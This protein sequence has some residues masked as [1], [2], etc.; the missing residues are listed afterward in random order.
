MADEDDDGGLGDLLKRLKNGQ[1]EYPPDL[2]DGTRM[3]Y[4]FRARQVFNRRKRGCGWY[5]VLLILVIL[6]VLFI[7]WLISQGAFT[8]IAPTSL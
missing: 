8:W 7:L 3:E 5:F 4:R 2:L 1:D 6:L